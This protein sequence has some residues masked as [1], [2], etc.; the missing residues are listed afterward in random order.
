MTTCP[1]CEDATVDFGDYV[2]R[3]CRYI[4]DGRNIC[5][6]CHKVYEPAGWEE[7]TWS[8]H[9][10]SAPRFS[11]LCL[12]CKDIAANAVPP[13]DQSTAA[14]AVDAWVEYLRDHRDYMYADEDDVLR[15]FNCG[16]EEPKYD[17]W[18]SQE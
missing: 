15:S 1:Q 12:M 9:V 5:D 7:M 14:Q 11:G 6:H 2:C 13:L 18:L 16:I 4:I 3:Q 10:G 8:E 17:T